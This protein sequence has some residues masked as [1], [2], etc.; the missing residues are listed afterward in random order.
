MDCSILPAMDRGIPPAVDVVVNCQ[1]PEVS[2]NSGAGG[3]GTEV[4]SLPPPQPQ[5]TRAETVHKV[6]AKTFLMEPSLYYDVESVRIV[7][8]WVI[9]NS[10]PTNPIPA[11]FTVGLEPG[12]LHLRGQ[13]V[14]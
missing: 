6:P 1:F 2:K 14:L 12:W 4:V 3:G 10:R 11:V 13:P 9:T 8:E 5:R 7:K